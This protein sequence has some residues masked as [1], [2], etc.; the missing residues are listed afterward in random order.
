MVSKYNIMLA[1][2]N[3]Y[4]VYNLLSRKLNVISSEL[5]EQLCDNNKLIETDEEQLELYKNG[6]YYNED[7]NETNIFLNKYY[8]AIYEP[9]LHITI[10]TTTSCNFSCKYCYEEYRGS[11]IDEDFINVMSKFIAKHIKDYSG[12]YIEWFG[13]EPL[14]AIEQI[15]SLSTKIKDI[16]RKQRKSYIGSMTTNGYLLDTNTFHRLLQ[17]NII[18]YQITVDGLEKEHDYLRPL[19][20]GGGSYNTILNNLCAI[21]RDTPS[22]KIFSIVIRNNI[23]DINMNSSKNFIKVFESFFSDD[24]RFKIYQHPIMDWGGNRI[25]EINSELSNKNYITVNGKKRM[26]SNLFESINSAMCSSN[27]ESSFV[28]DPEYNIYKCTHDVQNEEK[29]IGKMS[30]NGDI[31][32]QDNKINYYRLSFSESCKECSYLPFCAIE[33]CPKLRLEY[34]DC[35]KSV[36]KEILEILYNYISC[37]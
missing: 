13:G 27:R 17:S 18:F 11:C 26:Y 23:C 16:C 28:L 4:Y 3:S 21:K 6:M 8:K 7:V 33:R 37:L 25:D 24:L 12:V 22:S 19:K 15:I 2:D 34:K 35:K 29:C 5:Y 32:L 9:K 30:I 31:K 14:L 1:H 36:R 10:I 20:N